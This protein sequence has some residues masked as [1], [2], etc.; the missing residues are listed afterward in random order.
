[1]NIV[2]KNSIVLSVVGNKNDLY[3]KEEVS[4]AKGLEFAKK[5]KAS[6]KL[7]SALNSN[8]IIVINILIRLIS[9]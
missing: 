8:G 3:M 9:Q 7:T 6:F 2:E 5:H 4:D 1:M